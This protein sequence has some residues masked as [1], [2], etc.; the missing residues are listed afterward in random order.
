MSTVTPVSKILTGDTQDV[1]CIEKLIP[2]GTI[3]LPNAWG[4]NH[5]PEIFGPDA[6]LF[7]PARHLD[8]DTDDVEIG[9]AYVK[10]GHVIYGFGRR[11]CLGKHFANK[12]V[13]INTVLMLW[14]TDID[15]E[16]GPDG[17]VVGVDV[18]GCIDEGVLI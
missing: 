17:Q 9:F 1:W 10:E 4:I 15:G 7:N 12:M 6:H 14:A 2:K 13:L 8:M 3:L 18:D 11:V 16:R 5:D